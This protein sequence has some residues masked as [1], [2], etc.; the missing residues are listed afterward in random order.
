MSNKVLISAVAIALAGSFF[1]GANYYGSE[2][3]SAPVTP[4]AAAPMALTSADL[5]VPV[6]ATALQQQTLTD[7]LAAKLDLVVT[8]VSPSPIPGLFEVVTEQGIFYANADG[9]HLIQGALYQ[10]GDNGVVNLTEQAMASVRAAAINEFAD[11]MIRYPAADEKYAIT[12]F[13]DINCGYCRKLHDE[14][15]QY[16]DLGISVNYLAFPRGGLNSQTYQQMVSIWCADDPAAAMSNAKSGGTI[17][18]KTCANNVAEQYELGGR[19]GV[20]GTPAIVFADGRMQP[21][22]VPAAQLLNTLQQLAKG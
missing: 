11:D 2:S 14:L 17:A 3:V 16:N 10:V 22:Y 19:L 12:V 6:P 5:A 20:T 9:S 21:G 7:V 4:S 1:L 8:K 18:A 15:A 13:T